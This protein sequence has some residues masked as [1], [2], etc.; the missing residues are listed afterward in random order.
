MATEW[1]ETVEKITPFIVKVATPRGHGSGFLFAYASK[2]SLCAV[3]TAAHVVSAAAEWEEHVR[4]EQKT[5][6][7]SLVLHAHE[8]AIVLLSDRDTA[9]IIL[10]T[11]EGMFPKKPLRLA[12]PSKGLKIGVEIGWLG[13]PSLAPNNVCFFS[14]RIS[15]KLHEDRSYLVD[16]VAIN[17]VS[18]GPAFYRRPDTDSVELMGIVSA[19]LANTVVGGTLP[20]V[21]VVRHVDALHRV[22]K[23][24][25]TLSQARK[26]QARSVD[27]GTAPPLTERPPN[28]DPEAA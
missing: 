21:S 3:A 10:P 6:N 7:R 27:P 2:G 15:S 20:G 9:A 12:E 1:H 25:K 24:L 16:G 28:K 22:V 19:Y 8:R 17:G 4:L 14:G 23:N 18:G 11:P 5:S 26:E 13:F